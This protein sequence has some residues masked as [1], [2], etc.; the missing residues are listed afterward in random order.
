M[1]RL[2]DEQWERIREHFPEAT[3]APERPGRRPVPA[4]RVSS[5][6]R[7]RAVPHI[8]LHGKA[9]ALTDTRQH[10]NQRIDGEFFNFV[11]N[12]V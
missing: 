5:G 8:S 7:H 4:R 2:T 3:I 1:L 12:H 6:A 11:I 9:D 10:P